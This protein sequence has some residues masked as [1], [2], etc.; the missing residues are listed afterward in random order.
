MSMW[1][2]QNIWMWVWQKPPLQNQV[3]VQNQNPVNPFTPACTIAC[4]SLLR[5]STLY[6]YPQSCSSQLQE[7]HKRCRQQRLSQVGSHSYRRVRKFQTSRN[8]SMSLERFFFL[9]EMDGVFHLARAH[10]F[11]NSP[12]PF[13][14]QRSPQQ[15]MEHLQ[16][17]RL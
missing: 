2:L 11:A 6:W 4:A 5:M 15:L 8:D 16:C 10:P 13:S 14:Q 1:L 7:A 12:T 9:E 17:L 3:T